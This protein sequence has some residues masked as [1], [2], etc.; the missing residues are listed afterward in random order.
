MKSGIIL[1]KRPT[2]TAA[3]HRMSTPILKIENL[4]AKVADE[5]LQILKGVDLE[6]NADIASGEEE[7]TESK[8]AYTFSHGR[9]PFDLVCRPIRYQQPGR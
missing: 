4:Q 6:L 8:D 1:I 3:E 9:C 2:T 7:Y 5:D